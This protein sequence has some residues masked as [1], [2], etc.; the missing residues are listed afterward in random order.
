MTEAAAAS[1][2]VLLASYA[3]FVR[4]RRGGT[5]GR[6]L[7][8]VG[9]ALLIFIRPQLLPLLP[10]LGAISVSGSWWLRLRAAVASP[11]SKWTMMAQQGSASPKSNRRGQRTALIERSGLITG[12]RAHGPAVITEY[13]ATT[14][15]PR[16]GSFY[17]DK[18]GNLI[19]ET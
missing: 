1:V 5:L 15:V 14:W 3:L 19:I 12:R 10:V 13:S 17:L 18:A 4:S 8:G 9:G 16:G 7:L 2:L 6:A 11:K